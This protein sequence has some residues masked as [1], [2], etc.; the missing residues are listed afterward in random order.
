MR[1]VGYVALMEMTNA[2]RI[3]VHKM[4]ISGSLSDL[5]LDLRII[6]N[7]GLNKSNLRVKNGFNRLRTVSIGY[8]L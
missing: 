1:W 8:L 3:L 2:C 6:L 4:K 5:D 7:G